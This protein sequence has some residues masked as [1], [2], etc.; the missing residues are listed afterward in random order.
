[1]MRRAPK[2]LVVLV[3]I[4]AVVLAGGP[5]DAK[6]KTDPPPP[7][8]V[9]APWVEGQCPDI[10]DLN[11]VQTF[12]DAAAGHL[13]FVETIAADRCPEV[14]YAVYVYDTA[15]YSG[16]APIAAG[17]ATPGSGTSVTFDVV[18]DDLRRTLPAEVYVV[19]TTNDVFG[20]IDT[21]GPAIIPH[22][23]CIVTG[24]GGTDFR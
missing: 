22:G 24:C 13:H 12:Y 9:R 10:V 19:A 1:M 20:V 21:A 7:P 3:T 6:R 18:D 2:W 14:V 5:A 8:D 17:T 11:E 23:A 4:A 16:A 15:N